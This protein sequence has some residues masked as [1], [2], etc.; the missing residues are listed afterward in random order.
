MVYKERERDHKMRFKLLVIFLVCPLKNCAC[1]DK[2]LD[3]IHQR[4]FM[5]QICQTSMLAVIYS[6]IYLLT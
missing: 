6:F 1:K 4:G 2:V 5:N 3:E